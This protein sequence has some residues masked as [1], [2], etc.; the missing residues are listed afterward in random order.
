[1]MSKHSEKDMN[2]EITVSKDSL[3]KDVEFKGGF[4]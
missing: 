2:A 4:T 3:L 1:M